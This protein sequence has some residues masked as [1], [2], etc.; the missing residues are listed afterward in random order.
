MNIFPHFFFHLICGE[1]ICPA[2]CMQFTLSPYFK[3][4]RERREYFHT[5]RNSIEL[6]NTAFLYKQYISLSNIKMLQYINYLK[7]ANNIQIK[8]SCVKELVHLMCVS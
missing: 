7:N 6:Q 4:V 1:I 8:N 2:K 5:R 3:V